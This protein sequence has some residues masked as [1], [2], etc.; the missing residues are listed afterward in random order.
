MAEVPGKHYEEKPKKPNL[1]ER[2][3]DATG[4]VLNEVAEKDA[5]EMLDLGEKVQAL[6]S[7]SYLNVENVR[8]EGIVAWE[9]GGMVM[10][11]FMTFVGSEEM[12]SHEYSKYFRVKDFPGMPE[13]ELV[14]VY[15]HIDLDIE[16]GTVSMDVAFQAPDEL[17]Q[18][19]H[20]E[21]LLED[22]GR[23]KKVPSQFFDFG[24]AVILVEEKRRLKQKAE[25]ESE[26]GSDD[27]EFLAG[28]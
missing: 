12:R 22:G 8:A 18:N 2:V 4:E 1:K 21:L 27:A 25:E 24:N 5:A 23:G 28:N 3:V 6:K 9:K 11:W 14:N 19:Y 16:A 20:L 13:G 26:Y 7:L 15:M 17:F 10:E